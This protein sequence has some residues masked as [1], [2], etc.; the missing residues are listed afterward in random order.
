MKGRGS[1]SLVPD[2]NPK[3]A[4]T[5]DPNADFADVEEDGYDG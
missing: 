5:I 3:P 1:L 4:V 2:S